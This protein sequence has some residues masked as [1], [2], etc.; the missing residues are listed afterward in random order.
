M[1]TVADRSRPIQPGNPSA[2]IKKICCCNFIFQLYYIPRRGGSIIYKMGLPQI[3]CGSDGP[4][5]IYLHISY[6]KMLALQLF[7][8]EVY[9][10]ERQFNRV[11]IF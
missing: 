7:Q 11:F 9:S 2:A 10:P 5:F 8:T 3:A 1:A 6:F 4:E